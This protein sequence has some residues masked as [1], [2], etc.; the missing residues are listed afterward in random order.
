MT[1][2]QT[3]IYL[4]IV[5]NISDPKLFKIDVEKGGPESFGEGIKL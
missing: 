3:N 1:S 2:V 5:I 4:P